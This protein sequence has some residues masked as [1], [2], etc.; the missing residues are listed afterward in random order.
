MKTKEFAE[1]IQPH[2]VFPVVEGDGKTIIGD[3]T[4]KWNESYVFV[5]P[6]WRPYRHIAG[7]K[8][9]LYSVTDEA[10]LKNLNL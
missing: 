6:N 3:E 1:K 9:V 4:L 8:S 2:G 5:V 7:P 10:A